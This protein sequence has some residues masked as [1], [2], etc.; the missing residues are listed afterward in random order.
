MKILRNFSTLLLILGVALPLIFTSPVTAASESIYNNL[1]DSLPPSLPSLGYEA[2]STTE[3]GDQIAFAGTARNVTSA[4][5]TMVNWAL[6]STY[7]EMD[8]SGYTHPI[9]LNLYNV[10]DDNGTPIPGTLI[11]S[12]TQDFLIPWRP[13][14]DPACG[15]AWKASDGGCYNGYAFNIVFDFAGQNLI[16]PDEIIYGLAYNTADYGVEP[17]HQAGPYN[18]LNFGLV[19][20][21]PSV[22]TDL[23]PDAIFWNTSYAGFYS[24]AGAGGVGTFRRDTGWTG[25]VP[26]IR[27]D[28]EAAPPPTLTI[29][30]KDSQGNPIEGATITYAV[31]SPNAGWQTF[32]LTGPDGTF[33]RTD[34]AVGTT[35]HFYARY[36]ASTSLAQMVTFDGDDTLTFETVLVKAKVETCPGV[37]LAGA[38]VTYGSVNGGFVPFGTTDADGLAW[39][40]LFPGYERSFYAGINA[41]S[42]AL[43]TFTV[44]EQTDPLVT[45]QTT[46]VTINYGG[47]INHGSANGGW[48]PFTKPS[49]E[50]FA[51]LRT[52]LVNGI[53]VPV[54]VSGCSLSTGNLTVKFPGIASAHV[55]VKKSDGVMGTA[56]G[57]QVGEQT[58]KT[59]QA[60]FL[61]LPNNVYDVVV[62]KGAKTKII[63]DVVVIGDKTVENIV[64]TLTINFPGIAAVHTYARIPDGT[65]ETATGGGVEERTWK[66]DQ[67]V[68]T[69]LKGSY[70][71]VVVKGAKTNIIDAV[72][73]SG[74]TCL[75]EDIVATLTIN[76]PGI[77]AVH[78]YA[79]M[80]DGAAE[81]AT[82]GAVEERTWKNNQSVM[83]VLKGSYDVV[84]V[85][86]AKINIIDAVDCSG[87]T[88]LVD[89]LVATLTINFPGIAAVHTYARIP[90]GT[91]ETATGGGVEER[92]W[93]TDQSVMTVL[94]GSYDVVV[95][96]GAKTN[97]IDAVDCSGDT[98]LVEDIVATLTINFPGIAAVHTYARMPDGAAETA[99]GGAVEER[100]WKNNQSVMTVLKGSYDVVVVKGAK[101]NIIDAVDCSGD[102]CLV[103][104]IVATLTIKY[105]GLTAVHNYVKVPDGIDNSASGG[106]VD[107]RTWQ[108]NETS[109]AVLK[110]FYDVSIVKGTET[111]IYDNV[112]C[113]GITCTLDKANLTVK[114]PGIASVHT[115]V[116]KSDG[117]AGSATGLQVASQTWKTDQ[118]F[119]PGLANGLYDIVV[120]KGAR[121][122]IIDNVTILG[123]TVTIDKI[124]ATLTI[125]FPG[126]A[127]VHSYVKMPDAITG[128]ATGGAV[129]ERTWKTDSASMAVL[130]G[131]YDVAIIKGAQTKIIDNVDCNSDTCLVSDIVA[132]L[133][134]NFPGIASVHT[135]V[136]TDNGLA[137]TATGGAV[138]ER[139]WK[140]DSTSMAV[141]KASYDIVVIKGAQSK[142]IDAVD[143]TG[144]TCSVNDIV[145]TLTVNF[146]GIS[147]VHSYVK[148][149]DGTAGLA[150]GGAVDERT[151]KTD[152]T[153]MAVLKA[154]YDVVVIKGAK[155]LVV[156]DVDCTVGPCSVDDIVATLTVNFPGI[157][158][159]HTYVKMPDDTANTANGGAVEERT[160]KTDTTSMAVLKGF[161]DVRV[162]KGAK[163]NVVDD[164]DCSGDTCLVQDIVATL[165]VKFPGISSV[166]TYVKLDDNIV[167]TASGGAVDERTWK[168]NETSL[169]VLKGLYDVAVVKGAKTKVIDKVDCTT[170]TCTVE[171]IVATMT[172]N[173]PGLSSVHTYV[174]TDDGLANS[175]TGGAVDQQTWK[176]NK[177]TLVVLKNTYDVVVVAG[178][179]TTILDAV[180]CYGNT[181]EM[182]LA[183]VKLTNSLGTGLAGGVVNYYDGSWHPLGS[184]DA[185][186]LIRTGVVGA[187]RNL[188]F[189]IEYNFTRNEKW[190][191]ITTAPLV[192]FQTKNVVIDLK[193]SS[194]N[195]I[196]DSGGTGAVR[197]YTGAWHPFAGGITSEGSA[198]MELLPSNILFGI[199]HQFVYTEKWQDTTANANVLFQTKNVVIDLKDSSGNPILD[200]GGTGVVRYYTG[201]WHELG[202]T[203]DGQVNKELLPANILFGITH[204]FVYNEKWQNTS[205]DANVLFQTKNVVVELRDH[206][207]ALIP[208]SGGTATV[209]YYTGAWHEFGTT[210]DGQVNKELLPANILFGITHQFV[211][212][213]KWQMT[214]GNPLVS[215]KTGQVNSTSGNCTQYY[216]GSW[217]PFTNGMEL[218]PASIL[219]RFNDGTG[220]TWF[221]PTA[222]A[223]NTIH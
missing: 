119:F 114:F 78:T 90:D 125:D 171:N 46:N 52:F 71:V 59:D 157:S 82:G 98:C 177:T 167:A 192:S 218:L 217:H 80:P 124:V 70:D 8:A 109:L 135:Y 175:A 212:A 18:S 31:G 87:D 164:V 117:I 11:A 26:A 139:T 112:D 126:I 185:N 205:G 188:L 79:R 138:D 152:S 76:F 38:S 36:N 129:E 85:K 1:P 84:V 183:A 216:T 63:D 24:D 128:T 16:L 37:P 198:S 99:T 73:C 91:A 101:I 74:D 49:M 199:T 97:I 45:F 55:Y 213:E 6:H 127:S 48:Y 47:S 181:C 189:A 17:I 131:T 147:S 56:S 9:T 33:S 34:L 61:N 142:I 145:T 50:M 7:P 94:K 68:M 86:G 81:T 69:V 106:A 54:Q 166:H 60:V 211:Y 141:L 173:F 75:V 208:D 140:T 23:D 10:G 130:K 15:T 186:G 88:C 30:V 210:V 159:V 137:G 178:T 113:T 182:S 121:T 191:N 3:F 154:N 222:G 42:S 153:S 107:E 39:R 158:S 136:K 163:V 169:A 149:A 148:V 220:D 32:G 203:V 4:T 58:Y 35:Y 200:S 206:T 144:N 96:K 172:I 180:N 132:V 115:V 118:A 53:Q 170:N 174:K 13:E 44:T 223:A 92:T 66:T 151:W 29:E 116:R 165:T 104:D 160:W 122:K 146:P 40:E 21:A 100:T 102:T 168:T 111:F 20:P 110:G 134:V 105:P 219:F 150:G 207:G 67:S 57:L 28:V 184:T 51:G 123:G 65:A 221:T 22:G 179:T 62:V 187:P 72:D 95:V 204:Q 2:T 215:F 108:N 5:V 25:Y 190:Q 143:C 93:K 195:P 197:Y 196:P 83:T 12:V 77:A 209:R 14:A 19:A 162:V 194:G 43:Q 133:T 193:D 201:A 202:T 41:T 64:A 156:D 120:I 214:S 176:T 27:F 89:N 155:S 161:Y 103:E